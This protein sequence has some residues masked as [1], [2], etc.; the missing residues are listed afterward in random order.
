MENI[1]DA[2]VSIIIPAY[3]EEKTVGR[4]IDE[5]RDVLDSLQ[6]DYEVI[7]I[8]DGSSDATPQI[9]GGKE[10]IVF[11]RSECNEGYGASLKK[12]IARSRY[13]TLIIIDADGTYPNNKIPEL[14]KYR[15]EYDMVVA[16]RTGKDIHIPILRKIAK[17]ILRTLANYL[18]GKKIPDLNSGFRLMKKDQVRSILNILPSG[19][20]FTTTVTLAFLTSGRP[21]K[22]VPIDYDHRGRLSKFHPIKDTASMLSLIVRTILFFNPLKIFVPLGFVFI[23]AGAIVFF[24]SMFCLPKILDTTTMILAMAGIQTLVIGL[25]ADLIDRRTR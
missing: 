17:Y 22:Y 5:I 23:A 13:D 16:A 14:L 24:W 1:D 19:F 20:S 25:L 4:V 10:D 8:D 6:S 7:V 11:M 18:S 9:V 21:V 3:N 2:G 12:G 15:R